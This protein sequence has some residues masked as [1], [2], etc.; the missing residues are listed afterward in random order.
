MIQHL[1]DCPDFEGAGL[2]GYKEMMGRERCRQVSLLHLM[3][4]E[5]NK[6]FV[7]S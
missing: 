7:L 6:G 5:N 3:S 2:K 4:S 1:H